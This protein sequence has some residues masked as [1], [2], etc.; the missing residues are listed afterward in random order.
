MVEFPFQS[1]SICS[2]TKDGALMTS[3]HPG[4]RPTRSDPRPGDSIRMAR[5]TVFALALL[6][7]AL[8]LA[9]CKEAELGLPTS[10]ELV[11]RLVAASTEPRDLHSTSTFTMTM[12]VPQ[13]DLFG[14][15]DTGEMTIIADSETWTDAG[16]RMR[17]ESTAGYEGPGAAI[18]GSL[19][20]QDARTVVVR[21][22]VSFY[23][24]QGVLN[25]WSRQDIAEL[26]ER[27]AASGIPVDATNIGELYQE[28]FARMAVAYDVTIGGL[29]TVAGRRA[30]AFT[31]APKP[32]IADAERSVFGG[33]LLDHVD[34]SVDLVTWQPLSSDI[35]ASI[36]LS[37]MADTMRGGVGGVD[38]IEGMADAMAAAPPAA[39]RIRMTTTSIDYE[40]TLSEEIFT[41]TPPE[42]SIELDMAA[43]TLG[44]DMDQESLEQMMEQMQK[45][46]QDNPA[47]QEL[48]GGATADTP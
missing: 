25:I 17:S 34:M 20:G 3:L 48:L 2:P 44:E 9:A 32:G 27:M 37:A 29:R 43:F 7:I 21:D 6:P 36:D 13:L 10:E 46:L 5:R 15:G 24:Y 42:G 38:D 1:H 45:Q 41:F 28:L 39:F 19:G 31:A 33:V 26:E 12:S 18:M 16:G 23:Q 14:G 11:E 40:P 22:R 8:G 35:S 4:A 47:L 30:I